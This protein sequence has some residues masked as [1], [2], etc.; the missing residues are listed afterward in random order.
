[1]S[2]FK[3]ITFILEESYDFLVFCKCLDVKIIKKSICKTRK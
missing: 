3:M 2:W 1:M